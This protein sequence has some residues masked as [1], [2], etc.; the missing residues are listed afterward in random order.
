MESFKNC[1]EY[2]KGIEFDIEDNWDE[3]I[4]LKEL[5]ANGSDYGLSRTEN[6]NIFQSVSEKIEILDLSDIDTQYPT[7]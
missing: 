7:R 5:I 1:G 6:T 4:S 3:T 2:I